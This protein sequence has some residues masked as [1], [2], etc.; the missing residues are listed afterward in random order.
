MFRKP[1]AR[2]EAGVKDDFEEMEHVVREEDYLF[3][4]SVAPENFPPER[5]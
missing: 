3:R 1:A 2:R 5:P 4:C